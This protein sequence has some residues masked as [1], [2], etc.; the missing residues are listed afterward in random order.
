MRPHV[1]PGP[2]FRGSVQG[3]P[4]RFRGGSPHTTTQPD[5][6]GLR[7]GGV[8]H[9]SVGSVLVGG[10][11]DGGGC[12]EA[13]GR[14]RRRERRGRVEHVVVDDVVKPMDTRMEWTAGGSNGVAHDARTALQVLP[15]GR[16]VVLV[17]MDRTQAHLHLPTHHPSRCGAQPRSQ[18]CPTRSDE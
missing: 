13:Q 15:N 14:Q 7:W 4:R 2:T 12:N 9:T 6:T 17:R 16:I 11:G 18:T 1:D 3:G 10:C 8:G 5:T